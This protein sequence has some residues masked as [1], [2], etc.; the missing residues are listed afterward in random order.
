M[1]QELWIA[2][3]MLWVL[4]AAILPAVVAWRAVVSRQSLAYVS[5]LSGRL[6]RWG[7]FAAVVA[8]GVVLLLRLGMFKGYGEIPSGV[9]REVFLLLGA[10]TGSGLK[11]ICLYAL[12]LRPRRYINRYDLII[13]AVAVGLGEGIMRSALMVLEDTLLSTVHQ[14]VVQII[15]GMA[16]Q[17]VMGR[18]LI[19]GVDKQDAPAGSSY[20]LAWLLPAMLQ[21]AHTTLQ[22]QDSQAAPYLLTVVEAALLLLAGGIIYRVSAGNTHFSHVDARQVLDREALRPTLRQRLSYRFDALMS[23]GNLGL[24]G[25]LLLLCAGV[26]VVVGLLVYWRAPGAV[27]GKLTHALW[28]IFMRMIDSGNV[29][30][31][32]QTGSRFFVGATVFTTVFG[33]VGMSSLI[34]IISNV[35]SVKLEKLRAGHSKILEKGHVLFLGVGDDMSAMLEY[36]M[37]SKKSRRRLNVVLMDDLPQAE[38]E[39]QVPAGLYLRKGIRIQC[40]R[41]DIC[42]EHALDMVSLSKAQYAVISGDDEKG[43]T[44]AVA[45]KHILSQSKLDTPRVALLLQDKNDRLMAARYLDGRFR[46]FNSKDLSF[47]PILRGL[48][49]KRFLAVFQALTSFS[50]TDTLS[51]MPAG[52]AAGQSFYSLAGRYRFSSLVGLLRGGKVVLHPGLQDIVQPEDQLI[53]LKSPRDMLGAAWLP[54]ALA[55]MGLKA[56]GPHRKEKIGRILVLGT[57]GRERF[58][59]MVE[60]SGE[61]PVIDTQDEYDVP[62]MEEK[63]AAGGYDM[64]LCLHVAGQQDSHIM[65][66]L[67]LLHELLAG[68]D[69][70]LCAVL[71]DNDN[72]R[73]V[74]AH[75]IVDLVLKDDRERLIA[76]DI[77]AEDSPLQ[78]VEQELFFGEKGLRLLPAKETTGG[79]AVKISALAS[80]LAQ[81]GMLLLGFVHR[82]GEN[83]V[84]LNPNKNE[85]I[86]FDDHDDLIVV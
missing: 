45:I 13:F 25:A 38:L 1:G 19:S 49:E 77:L 76:S 16:F 29:S 39:A 6:M 75:R 18:F 68:Q 71:A 21:Y 85:T 48:Q 81:Q 17:V 7:A 84:I 53:F 9:Q 78:A 12:A 10:L 86:L 54:G 65:P 2:L 26:V 40:R 36:L 50:R 47:A 55:P 62:L 42:D 63:I 72:A 61:T 70:Y 8:S 14:N 43:L 15:M 79:E 64:V 82:L 31:D 32:L 67:L 23:A 5:A 83:Q 73:Y 58:L 28:T 22:Y 60:Q 44:C 57:Q 41:G 80:A 33:L 51:V 30:P 59:H 52:R 35:L 66:H 4:L 20:L 37:Q 46:V 24:I 3:Q 11:L 69:C 56:L 74:Y 27:S 34:G